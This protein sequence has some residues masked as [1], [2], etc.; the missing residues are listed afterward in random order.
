[1]NLNLIEWHVRQKFTLPDDF[2]FYNYE[3]VPDGTFDHTQLTG[4]KCPVIQTGKRKGRPNFK[5]KVPGS[6]RTFLVPDSEY[7]H[8]EAKWSATTGKCST[9]LGEGKTVAGVSVADGTK[10]LECRQCKG[11]GKAA[12]VAL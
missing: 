10:Y 11:S 6:R 7:P 2:H 1:M 3:S 4:A 5:Q 12:E 9:C 8:I